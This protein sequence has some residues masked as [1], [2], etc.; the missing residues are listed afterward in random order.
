[1]SEKFLKFKRRRRRLRLISS[2]ALGFSLGAVFGAALLLL[3]KLGWLPLLPV[4]ALIV[5]VGLFLASFVITYFLLRTSDVSTAKM[6]DNKF[7]L[8]ERVLTML[9]YGGADSGIAQL[10]RLDAERVLDEISPREIKLPRPLLHIASVTLSAALLLTSILLPSSLIEDPEIPDVPFTLSEIQ[11]AGIEELISYVAESSMQESYRNTV[12]SSLELL[13]SELI[14]ADTMAERDASLDKAISVI[15]LATDASDSSPEIL[16]QIYGRADKHLK[17]LAFA[18]YAGRYADGGIVVFTEKIAVF[19]SMLVHETASSDRIDLVKMRSDTVSLLELISSELSSAITDTE[20]ES[21]TPLLKQ[22]NNLLTA[23]TDNYKGLAVLADDTLLGYY[24]LQTELDSVVTYL[25]TPMFSTLT[26]ERANAEVGE[27]VLKRI[28]E[29]FAYDV[30]APE[31]PIFDAT[32]EEEKENDSDSSEDDKDR[33]PSDGGYGSGAVFGSDDIVLD[34]RTGELV[35]YGELLDEFYAK[36]FGKKQE[37]KYT[38]EEIEAVEKY[39]E[40]LYK[41]FDKNGDK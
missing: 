19:R 16:D 26:T 21:D 28:G 9:E 22:L 31:R 20:L 15:S 29:L 4:Y 34:Y 13:L 40:I 37:G 41:G 38:E 32:A 2:L 24:E 11:R 10:Q 25:L 33:E 23:D 27:R 39:F 35:K 1:M 12:G 3:I 36:M 18:L 7:G 17:A 8:N 6:L 5:G 30:P 14:A